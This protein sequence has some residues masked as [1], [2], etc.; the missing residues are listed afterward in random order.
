MAKVIISSN[1]DARVYEYD[2]VMKNVKS[3]ARVDTTFRCYDK[4]ALRIDLFP[5]TIYHTTYHINEELYNEIKKLCIEEK[6]TYKN[7]RVMYGILIADAVRGYSKNKDFLYNALVTQKYTRPY[8]LDTMNFYYNNGIMR[9]VPHGSESSV[10]NKS[11]FVENASDSYSKIRKLLGINEGKID[12]T[13][14]IADHRLATNG[15]YAGSCYYDTEGMVVTEL[16]EAG[17]SLI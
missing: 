1:S 16:F 13:D 7:E 4:M 6:K 2:S 10:Y 9:C 14:F 12:V 3:H 17:R 8:V 5:Y 15:K 11:L